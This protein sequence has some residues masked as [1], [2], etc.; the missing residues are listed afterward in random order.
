MGAASALALATLAFAFAPNPATPAPNVGVEAEADARG[1]MHPVGRIFP[2]EQPISSEVVDRFKV[3]ARA[4]VQQ[5]AKD[6]KRPI[7]FLHSSSPDRPASKGPASDLARFLTQRAHRR[8]DGRLRL[9]ARWWAT[10]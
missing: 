6:G 10:P 2:I 4:L 7:L 9:G 3:A 1:P 5:A 8:A